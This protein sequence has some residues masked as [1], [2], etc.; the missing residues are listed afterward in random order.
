MSFVFQDE[1][2]N[3]FVLISENY[4]FH[5]AVISLLKNNLYCYS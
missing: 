1:L 3:K 5:N 4:N 2:T